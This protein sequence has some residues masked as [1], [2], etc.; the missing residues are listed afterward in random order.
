MQTAAYT[1][2]RPVTPAVAEDLARI[3]DL[4]E[5][6][7]AVYHAIRQGLGDDYHTDVEAKDVARTLGCDV[8]AVKGALS[9]LESRKVVVRE[10]YERRVYLNTRANAH[11][12]EC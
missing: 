7:R 1:C 8:A 11:H 10:A 9:H 5:F 4:P 6:T 2:S 3:A 12:G